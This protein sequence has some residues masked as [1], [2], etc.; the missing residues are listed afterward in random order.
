MDTN[1]IRLILKKLKFFRGVY[2]ADQIPKIKKNRKQ[3]SAFIVNTHPMRD[4]GEHWVAL[5]IDNKN[6]SNQLEFFDSF[7]YNKSISFLHSKYF[8]TFFKNKYFNKKTVFTNTHRLQDKKSELCGYY[9]VLFL[10]LRCFSNMDFQSII[11]KFTLKS[12]K[13]ND[14]SII[15]LFKQLLW[16]CNRMP[17]EFVD[18][19]TLNQRSTSMVSCIKNIR[20]I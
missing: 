1:Q 9:C 14:L 19:N 7:G 17:H 16:R 5:Y 10:Y 4:P 8:K 3:P 6:D 2:A 18:K 13:R 20:K 12:Y 15:K 11:N